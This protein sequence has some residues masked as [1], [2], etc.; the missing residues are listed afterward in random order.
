M[1]NTVTVLGTVY[2]I[3]QRNDTDDEQ[4]KAD[5]GGYCD[6]HKRLIVIRRNWENTPDM[7]ML[8]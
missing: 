6:V 3:E 8:K 4:L 7:A 5:L 2:K 1:K